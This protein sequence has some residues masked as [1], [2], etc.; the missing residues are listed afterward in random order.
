MA[1]LGETWVSFRGSRVWQQCNVLKLTIRQGRSGHRLSLGHARGVAPQTRNSG[2]PLVRDPRS[3]AIFRASRLHADSHWF[4]IT[5]LTGAMVLGG[6]AFSPH[7]KETGLDDGTALKARHFLVDELPIAYPASPVVAA[8]HW[9][10]GWDKQGRR[11][12]LCSSY[13]IFMR[14]RHCLHNSRALLEWL[15]L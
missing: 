5:A 11:S 12:I 1:S 9:C 15:V 6:G 2:P 13:Q 3:F 8:H 10:R 4:L 14:G 7:R